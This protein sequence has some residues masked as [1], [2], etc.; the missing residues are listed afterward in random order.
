MREVGEGGK[1]RPNFGAAHCTTGAA[2]AS[3]STAH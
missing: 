1:E 3:L 2:A